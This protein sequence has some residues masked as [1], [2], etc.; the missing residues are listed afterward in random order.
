MAV[1]AA[2]FAVVAAVALG[3]SATATASTFASPQACCDSLATAFGPKLFPSSSAE[4]AASIK[5]YFTLQER[6][7]PTCVV[8]PTAAEDV[9]R[10]VG[11]L[12]NQSC[13]FAVRGGGHSLVLGA[14]N[15][16]DGVTVDLSAM[17]SVVL[18]DDR[19]TASIGPGCRWGDVYRTLDALGSAVPGGRAATVGVAGLTL[20]GGNSFFTARKGFVCDNVKNFE[21]VLGSGQIVNAN[22][23]SN[24]DLFRCLKG[25]SNNFGIV[26]RFDMEA[27]DQGD[28]WG[29]YITYEQASAP[30]Q[31][32]GFTEFADKIAQD[33]YASLIAVWNYV[34]GQKS[35]SNVYEYTKPEAYPAIFEN[36]TKI[37]PELLSTM[38][39]ASLYNITDELASGPDRRSVPPSSPTAVAA[40]PSR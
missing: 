33:P 9:A 22:R 36:L 40:L 29:G 2:T 28:L 25:G 26:T 1:T 21:I 16:E 17:K 14:A 6:I 11:L 35:I 30:D 4:Y 13:Q 23:T 34:G 18:S 31:I 15:I 19:T 7:T 3:G 27:F 39:I 38:R 20:G 32:A 8:A 12:A 5:S 37:K 24:E 10:I